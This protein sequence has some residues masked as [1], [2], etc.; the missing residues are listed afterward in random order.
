MR[1][2]TSSG[3][4]GRAADVRLHIIGINYWP[5]RTGIALVTTGRAEY[6][7]A[8]GHQV[9]VC[10]ALPYYPEWRIAA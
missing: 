7:A 9:T 10:T 2:P 5:E 4:A 3:S 6:L 1:R 8:R